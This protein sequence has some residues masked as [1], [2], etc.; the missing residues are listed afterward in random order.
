MDAVR[1]GALGCINLGKGVA[2]DAA[3][4]VIETPRA[5]EAQHLP[6]PAM[7][8]CFVEWSHPPLSGRKSVTTQGPK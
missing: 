8:T 6:A 2:C 5:V 7:A 4:G 3:L 1:P